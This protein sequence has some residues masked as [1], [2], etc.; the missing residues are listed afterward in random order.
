MAQNPATKEARVFVGNLSW[1]TTAETLGKTFEKFGNVQEAVIVAR[2]GR[3]LGFGFV[4]M[5]DAAAAKAA[6]SALQGTELDGRKLRVEASTGNGPHPAGSRP[7]RPRGGFRGGFRGFRGG[8]RGFR[9]GFRG[10]R[11][12]RQVNPEAPLSKT[13]VY[14]GSIPYSLKD[15]EFKDAFKQ[16]NPAETLIVRAFDGRNLGFGFVECRNEEDQKKLVAVRSVT[17]KDRKC[18]LAP[19]RERPPRQTPAPAQ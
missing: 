12:R 1:N 15:E 4:T 13:R 16:Y 11:P 8:Y 19:A 9:G 17:I 5:A 7:R 6:I 18:F 14:V 2:G 3:S 10:G